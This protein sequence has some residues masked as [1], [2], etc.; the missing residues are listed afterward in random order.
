M[1]IVLIGSV[2]V[3]V[4]YL[5]EKKEQLEHIKKGVCPQCKKLGIELSDQRLG[6]CSTPTLLFFYLPRVQ[7][8]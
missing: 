7:L 3:F 6:G 8:Y 5:K 1:L 2:L 4:Y